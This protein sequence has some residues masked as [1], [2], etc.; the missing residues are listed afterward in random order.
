[1]R[2]GS[3][4]ATVEA[5]RALASE[6][7]LAAEM[8]AANGQTVVSLRGAVG[9][10]LRAS[11]ATLPGVEAVVGDA[12]PD[13]PR[14]RN[15]RIT[16]IRPLLPPTILLESGEVERPTL[17]DGDPMNAF[18]AELR[19]VTDSVRNNRESAILNGALA[20][21]AVKL[22]EMQAQSMAAAS[23]TVGGRS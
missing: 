16:S 23:R 5:V 15:L 9:Q 14:T 21:D 10:D 17:S 13:A 7:G 20:Q 6:H 3:S 2:P 4:G 1:M 12:D 11:L 22:C 8:F 19:E 18:E